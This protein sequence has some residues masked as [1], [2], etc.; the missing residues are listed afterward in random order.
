MIKQEFYPDDAYI[1]TG[2]NR[3]FE[4]QQQQLPQDINLRDELKPL[5]VACYFEK[6]LSK[7]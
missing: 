7:I 4:E 3:N 2:V 1:N 6:R 5:W